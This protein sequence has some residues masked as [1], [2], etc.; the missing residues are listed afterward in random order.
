LIALA[1]DC[2][3]AQFG[4]VRATAMTLQGAS[5]KKSCG[6]LAEIDIKSEGERG[7]QSKA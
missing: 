6:T 4:S 7:T 2:V 5:G 1:L 3:E